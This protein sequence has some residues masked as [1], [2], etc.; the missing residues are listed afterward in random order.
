MGK[1]VLVLTG[2]PRKGGNT[3][4]LAEAFAQGAREA[5]C[6]LSIIHAAEKHIRACL[7]CNG[8]FETGGVCVQKDDD[9]API[10]QS[11]READVVVFATPVYFFGVTA[12]LKLLIDRTYAL[13]PAGKQKKDVVVLATCGN[14]DAAVCAPT[15]AMFREMIHF[16][17]A[18]EKGLILAA[19]LH[20]PGEIAGR[21]E[22]EQ[23][24]ALGRSLGV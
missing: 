21:P 13:L 20:K 1:N 10:L 2:S 5:G 19:G 9:M 24:R 6:E 3:Q 16:S 4:L 18:T 22:L 12:Q 14:G 8:C 11:Y 23:A 7:G 17:G 15:V